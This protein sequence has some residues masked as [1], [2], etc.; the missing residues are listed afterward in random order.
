MTII[1]D[2]ADRQY[3]YTDEEKA[4]FAVASF[5]EEM[6]LDDSAVLALWD[7]E[8]DPRRSELERRI[9]EAVDAN[10]PV[11]RARETIPNGISLAIE[12]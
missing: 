7:S 9:F 3:D 8:R 6:S 1:V 12:V 11:K 10:G 5:Q 2:I 4:A